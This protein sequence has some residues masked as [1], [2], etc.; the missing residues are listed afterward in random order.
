MSLKNSLIIQSDAYNVFNTDNYLRIYLICVHPSSKNL[1]QD[2]LY[3]SYELT[4]AL[5]LKA[6]AGIFTKTRDQKAAIK[7]GFKFISEI[8]YNNWITK[9]DNIRGNPGINNNSVAFMGRII[10]N[11]VELNKILKIRK[12]IWKMEKDT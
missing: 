1:I 8:Q 9:D 12:Q 4:A 5:N 3:S 2:L 10:P 6:V 11:R 7:I